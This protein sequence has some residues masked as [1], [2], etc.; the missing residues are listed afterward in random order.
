MVRVSTRRYP[1]LY[2]I[3]KS[4]K[5]DDIVRKKMGFWF[6]DKNAKYNV[7]VSKK[8]F[9]GRTYMP[10]NDKVVESVYALMQN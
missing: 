8:K 9:V 2:V 4:V 5:N 6:Y 3:I 10:Y 1:W 7:L